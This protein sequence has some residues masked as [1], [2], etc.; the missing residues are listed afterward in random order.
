MHKVY[1]IYV[2]LNFKSFG[3]V[4]NDWFAV[5]N[6][7]NICL[8]IHPINLNVLYFWTLYYKHYIKF[9]TKIEWIYIRFNI[10]NILNKPTNIKL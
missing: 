9:D 10:F 6:A 5:N 8:R 7:E 2:L 3:W 4:D 1:Y